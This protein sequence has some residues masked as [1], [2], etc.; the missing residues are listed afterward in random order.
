MD[1]LVQLLFF[2]LEISNFEYRRYLKMVYKK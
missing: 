1:V 2:I